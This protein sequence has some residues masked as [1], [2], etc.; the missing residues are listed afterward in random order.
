MPSLHSPLIE[1]DFLYR[2]ENVTISVVAYQ[3]PQGIPARFCAGLIAAIQLYK[4]IPQGKAELR[5]IDPSPIA[6][7]CNNWEEGREAHSILHQFCRAHGI[8]PFFDRAEDMTPESL[9][10]LRQ[11]GE[12]LLSAQDPNVKEMV[13]RI[14][15]SGRQHGGAEGERNALLYMAAHPFSWLDMYHSSLWR[16]R[17]ASQGTRYVNLMSRAEM[18]FTRIREYLRTHE[19]FASGITPEDRYMTVCNTPC[20]IPF[21]NEPMHEDLTRNGVEA[22]LERYR[23]MSRLSENHRRARKDMEALVP[24]LGM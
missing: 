24:F 1:G 3:H 4:A 16:R 19:L 11:I 10:I 12:V 14:Q 6:T 13:A 7:Y 23:A 2:E 9:S 21:P 20:Y 8:E 15:S 22:C 5:I 17:H 18:R